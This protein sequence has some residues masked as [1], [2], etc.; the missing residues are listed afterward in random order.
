[1]FLDLMLVGLDDI[2]DDDKVNTV[3]VG[4]N[5]GVVA[6]DDNLHANANDVNSTDDVTGVVDCE[7]DDAA[8]T[9]FVTD[10]DGAADGDTGDTAAVN[11]ALDADS[12]VPV[13]GC[14]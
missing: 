3:V 7:G 10:E 12:G 2:S 11:T 8:T 14:N 13:C 4:V 6:E 9:D 5:D 1:M